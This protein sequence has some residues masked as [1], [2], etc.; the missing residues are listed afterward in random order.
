[1]SEQ[2]AIHI[3]DLEKWYGR[4]QA[5]R[6]VDLIVHQGEVFGFL[7]PNGAGKTTTIRCMLDLIRPQ[8]GSIRILGI[9]P[10]A[11]PV[12]V[13]RRVGYLPGE[14]SMESN[15]RV[16]AQL[17]YYNDLRGNKTDWGFVRSLA[18]RL[19][20]DLSHPIKNLSKGNKQKVGVVQALMS[21][22]ELLL[23]DEPTAGLDPL[24]Q[25]EVYRMLRE[26]QAEGATIFFSSHI[27]SEVEA[28]ADRVAIIRK[29]VIVE[30]AEPGQLVSMAL[31]RMTI[32]FRGPVVPS[33]LD[34]VEGVTILSQSDGA[35]VT[36]QVEGEVDDLIKAL[37]AYPVSD[38]DIEHP[39]L[40]E[41]FLAYYK[42]GEKETD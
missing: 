23:M 40:E 8:A 5:L 18:K 32:R 20:L 21:R 29:G 27:I 35:S 13:R 38:I 9:N 28:L 26:A 10:Q 36:L 2:H 31:R 1:M 4:V 14:L 25:Q 37:S 3:Q 6:D 16:Q 34:K 12:A 42:A 24:M 39:S 41:I 19:D 33:G 11:D 15:L 17:R 30:E 7:G 22:P